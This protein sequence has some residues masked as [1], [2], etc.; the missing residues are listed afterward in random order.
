MALVAGSSCLA[1]NI[2]ARV[3]SSGGF[4]IMMMELHLVQ[5]IPASVPIPRAISSH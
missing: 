3:S 5:A 1:K 2:D 4:L